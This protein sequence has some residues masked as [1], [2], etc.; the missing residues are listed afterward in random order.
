LETI[1][2][3]V[4]DAQVDVETG[5]I[6]KDKVVHFTDDS[7]QVHDL[8]NM[9]ESAKEGVR[10]LKD[11]TDD[12]LAK[13]V[14]RDEPKAEEPEPEAG[15]WHKEFTKA[16]IVSIIN[17]RLKPKLD[18]FDYASFKGDKL[19]ER[20]LIKAK[21]LELASFAEELKEYIASK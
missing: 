19:G 20:E 5:K 17:E 13:N 3:I 6:E 7:P 21:K 10:K 15:V 16:E 18:P 2:H 9:L 4:E 11:T 12:L 14:I 1:S 8:T